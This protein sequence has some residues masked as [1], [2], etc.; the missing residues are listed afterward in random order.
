MP[1]LRLPRALIT[2]TRGRPSPMTGAAS[3][4]ERLLMRRIRLGRQLILAANCGQTAKTWTGNR[5]R[6]SFSSR[7]T[8]PPWS[9]SAGGLNPRWNSRAGNQSCDLY[10]NLKRLAT[11]LTMTSEQVCWLWELTGNTW[12]LFNHSVSPVWL[13]FFLLLAKMVNLRLITVKHMKL[14]CRIF[15]IVAV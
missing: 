1:P 13:L 2:R 15:L 6:V 7:G 8:V 11:P 10:R 3:G 9:A 14:M 5:L 4:E 12:S